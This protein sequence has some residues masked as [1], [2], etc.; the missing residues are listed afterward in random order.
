MLK[1]LLALWFQADIASWKVCAQANWAQQNHHVEEIHETLL[2][3]QS[4]SQTYC[5]CKKAFFEQRESREPE[6]ARSSATTLSSE[7]NYLHIS[8]FFLPEALQQG[9]YND[10]F[11]LVPTTAQ[12]AMGMYQAG[13]VW[14]LKMILSKR[15]PLWSQTRSVQSKNDCPAV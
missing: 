5:S 2:D 12:S 6:A 8:W 3:E 10:S 9:I 1:C 14:P 11:C 15:S 13:W 7:G 4:I